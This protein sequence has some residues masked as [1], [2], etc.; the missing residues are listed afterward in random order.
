MTAVLW[1]NDEWGYFDYNLT[2]G[3]RQIYITSDSN[4]A[5]GE[6]STA[7]EG[8]QIFTHVAQYYPFWTGAAPNWLKNNPSAVLR[9]FE[10]I[11]LLLDTFPGAPPATNLQTNQQWDEPN[12]WPP[13]TYILIDGLLN[14]PATFGEDDPSY[15]TTQDLALEI[16]QRYLDSAFCT[17]R[18]TG[19]ATSSLPMLESVEEGDDY[20]GAIF[21]KYNSTDVTAFGGGGEY[22]VQLGFGWS[23]GV[24]IWVGDVFGS[25][26]T[27]PSCEQQ[28]E[29]GGDGGGVVNVQKRS[30][31][32]QVPRVKDA[33][34]RRAGH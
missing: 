21:E 11:E 16:A 4:V 1:D 31:G 19:G 33:R 9:A 32:Q 30:L 10:R 25:E 3:G 17:W 24:L 23:N 14:T 2:A 20:G 18:T 26:L 29:E 28:L 12:V 8:Q 15:S 7:P 34:W 27:L 22:E 6:N 5:S 13:L